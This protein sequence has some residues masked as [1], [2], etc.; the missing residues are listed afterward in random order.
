MKVS[1]KYKEIF[2]LKKMLEDANIP[3]EFIEGF[4]FADDKYLKVIC[5]DLLDHYQLC[6]PKKGEDQYISVIEGFGT[7]GEERDRLEILG[8]F[9]PM[10]ELE[11]GRTTPIGGLTAKNVF[12]RIKDH[13]E[14]ERKL[15][16]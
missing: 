14:K 6:Y 13:Y 4:G 9:T 16:E 8:G 2:K 11:N 5:P 15:Y 3:F 7:Y 10:E 12:K 1:R